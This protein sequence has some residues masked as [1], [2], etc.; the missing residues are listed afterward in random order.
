[1]QVANAWRPAP[2]TVASFLNQTTYTRMK[3]LHRDSK[4]LFI[5]GESVI[6]A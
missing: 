4:S 2:A 6:V 5:I 1:M 3:I